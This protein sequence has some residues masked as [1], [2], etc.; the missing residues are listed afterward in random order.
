MGIWLP[1]PW[2]ASVLR[3]SRPTVKV[4][5]FTLCDY[6]VSV[7]GG[8]LTIVGTFDRLVVPQI[9]FQQ[10]GFFIVGKFRF[11]ADEVGE[12]RLKF[13]IS[14]PD[15]RLLGSLP[16]I[17]IPVTL[18]ADEYTAA[19]QVVLRINGMPISTEGDHTV[20]LMIDEVLQATLLLTIKQL[21]G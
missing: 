8:K 10:P 20:Q 2:Q 11:D 3:H 5:I 1:S 19:M 7:P 12:K 18:R 4:E 13:S 21:A 15:N 9:P 14:D 17:K 16:E 6:A